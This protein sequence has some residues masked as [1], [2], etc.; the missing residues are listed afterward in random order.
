MTDA[1]VTE[2][3][4]AAALGRR[5][6]SGRDRRRHRGTRVSPARDAVC[7]AERAAGE[8]QRLSYHQAIQDALREEM[9]RQPDLFIIGEDVGVS[10]ARSR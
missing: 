3:V 10:T 7:A 9:D 6:E 5:G 1:R 8:G 4:T 2:A